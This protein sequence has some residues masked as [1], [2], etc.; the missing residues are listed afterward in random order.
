[1]ISRGLSWKC[2]FVLVFLIIK[3]VSI[4][5]TKKVLYYLAK[6]LPF[7]KILPVFKIVS[8]CYFCLENRKMSRFER[9]KPF[10]LKRSNRGPK[11]RRS[12][13][14]RKQGKWKEVFFSSDYKRFWLAFSFTVYHPCMHW[15]Q[16]WS[17][18]REVSK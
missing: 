10:H 17:Q 18:G 16:K 11:G 4:W 13:L 8:I 7:Q 15:L 12:D 14:K 6:N 3:I 2:S 1:M 5:Y 9:E